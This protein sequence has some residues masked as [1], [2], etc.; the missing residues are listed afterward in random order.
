MAFELSYDLDKAAQRQS[1]NLADIQTLRDE[2]VN[3]APKGVTDK[4][5]YMIW[6]NKYWRNHI[7]C[8]L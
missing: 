2:V 6:L 3:Y 1:I 8:I 4:Q 7:N 5:V